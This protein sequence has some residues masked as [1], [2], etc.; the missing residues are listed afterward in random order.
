MPAKQIIGIILIKN[1]DIHIERVIRNILNFCDSIIVTDH[2]SE[3]RTFE[4][5]EN[6]AKEFP[7][8]TLKK[9]N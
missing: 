9:I 4:I 2:Q 3:D 5:V 8:I 7:Q 6:L 1:E